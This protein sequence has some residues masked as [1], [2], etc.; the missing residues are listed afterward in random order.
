MKGNATL[1]IF[2][3]TLN[4]MRRTGFLF[5]LFVATLLLQPVY[6][7]LRLTAVPGKTI[8]QRNETFQLQFV[9]EGVAQVD[10][11]IPPSFRNFE[12][13]GEPLQSSGWTWVNGSLTEYVSYTY[14][15]KPRVTGKLPI[16]SAVA[17]MKGK[18]IS[19]NPLIILVTE[20]AAPTGASAGGDEQKPD[21]F[22]YP[23]ENAKEKIEK[24]LFVKVVVDKQVCVVGEPVLASFKLYTRL[25]S[26]SKIIKRP[27]FNGFSVVDLAEPETGL[28]TREIYNG[29]L[30][31]TYLIRQVQLFP[32]Q[33]GELTIESV[34]V[35]NRVRFIRPLPEQL[36]KDTRKW[37][38]A[39]VDQMKRAELAAENITEEELV[40][41]TPPITIQ[42]KEL[43]EQG[44]PASFTGVVGKFLISASLEK[45]QLHAGENGLLSI[46]ISG[47]GNRSLIT[48]P[49]I[50]WPPGMEAYEPRSSE[51][52]DPEEVPPAGTKLFEIPF[53][54]AP[55]TY[56]I[57]PIEFSFFDPAANSYQEVRTSPLQVQVHASSVQQQQ[58]GLAEQKQE[59]REVLPVMSK[60]AIAFMV[61]FIV[62]AVI[63]FAG[64]KRRKKMPAAAD[65]LP[66][67]EHIPAMAFLQQA[68]QR[69]LF[70]DTR[71]WCSLLLNS[72]KDY[73]THR[74][75]TEDNLLTSA[76]VAHL[77]QQRGELHLAQLFQQ[78]TT[79][80]ETIMYSPVAVESQKEMLLERAQELL[81]VAEQRF[82]LHAQSG[83]Q[84]HGPNGSSGDS[85]YPPQ[86]TSG[87]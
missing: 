21:Y 50:Q 63:G 31:N 72:V 71:E 78:L 26:E 32:L 46:R 47:S 77:L 82:T 48:A 75:E 73:F 39:I 58:T 51:Q 25:E 38:D 65:L 55:G 30:Y 8:V 45:S 54:A 52:K 12:V 59:K 5:F 4:F 1:A 35:E 33:S 83:N 20:T 18:A 68:G 24:N 64:L 70:T 41:K 66:E 27:S 36:K 61:L 34:E 40:I 7:Q 53:T 57:P 79:T 15:L 86:N 80:C 17:R 13:A 22:L 19:S 44:K 62:L 2:G 43:P 56:S 6:A 85:G 60:A 11:F 76:A 74:L 23:G 29:R 37:M 49:A 84:H 81:Q 42:V 3:N 67:K 87:S 28:F 14:Q 10:E 9:A 16:A 69:M